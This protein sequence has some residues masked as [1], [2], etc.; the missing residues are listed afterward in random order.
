VSGFKH[1]A[2]DDQEVDTIMNEKLLVTVT[3]AAEMLNLGRSTVYDLISIGELK[4][5]KIGRAARIPTADLREFVDRR[6]EAS[7]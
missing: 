2:T 4:V 1:S 3:E 7:S 6:V 5:V